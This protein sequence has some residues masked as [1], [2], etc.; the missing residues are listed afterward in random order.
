[1]QSMHKNDVEEGGEHGGENDDVT[2]ETAQDGD[3]KSR[4]EHDSDHA[5]REDKP[6]PE[7][8][9]AA[10]EDF[11]AEDEDEEA[12]EDN[13]QQRRKTSAKHNSNRRLQHG[14]FIVTLDGLDEGSKRLSIQTGTST[15]DVARSRSRSRDKKSSAS[16]HKE[17]ATSKRS[18]GAK[19]G[20]PHAKG[21]RS[22]SDEE[23][24]VFL[25]ERELEEKEKQ[26]REFQQRRRRSDEQR[27]SRDTRDHSRDRHE[28]RKRS[29]G[30]RG[31]SVEKDSGRQTEG[32]RGT[33]V[34]KDSAD[35]RTARKRRYSE[36]EPT[37]SE[38]T[39]SLRSR[40][41][42]STAATTSAKKSTAFINPHFKPRTA[43]HQP[44]ATV[45]PISQV[46][47]RPPLISA[48]GQ[49]VSASLGGGGAAVQPQ[50]IQRVA[51]NVSV[52]PGAVIIAPSSAAAQVF[53]A[54][55]H[56]LQRCQHWPHCKNENACPFVHP[57]SMCNA[58]PN[59]TLAE[60]C[61]FI[62]PTCPYDG[63]CSN[64]ACLYMHT[65]TVS[66]RAGA[67]VHPQQQQQQ[68]R[69]VASVPRSV[70]P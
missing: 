14:Q 68:Q 37:K 17:Q 64:P 28:E 53:A 44:V 55:G 42:D 62:H 39:D 15:A 3:T 70:I 54:S 24:E 50:M 41:P 32:R 56:V 12:G 35:Q 6:E 51:M 58:F 19:E 48:A 57:T 49:L 61:N 27:D 31:T 59:C 33:S 29:D 4:L 69:H 65:N 22:K 7:S 38:V 9:V 46:F 21:A 40:K 67:L 1:M 26:R 25:R 16:A 11:E 23:F 66:S 8:K 63:R 13:D 30:R 34:E 10:E 2:M 47:S 43:G 60:K 36:D 45:T 5:D 52:P 20:K 18:S